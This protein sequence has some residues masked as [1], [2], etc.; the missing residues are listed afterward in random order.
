MSEVVY[1][2]ALEAD[3]DQAW[4]SLEESGCQ[5]LYS[6]QE[7]MSQQIIGYLPIHSNAA[8]VLAKHNFVKAIISAPLPAIDWDAQWAAHGQGYRDGYLHIDLHDFSPTLR[9]KTLKLKPGPGFGDL[10]HPTTRLVLKLMHQRMQQEHVI[11]VGCGS[12]I[13]ALAALSMGA[14]SV[15]AID[16][17]E[18]ALKHAEINCRLNGMQGQIAFAKP[19]ECIPHLPKQKPLSILMNMIHSEQMQAWQ[20]LRDIHGQVRWAI[21]SGILCE[22]EKEYLKCCAKWGWQPA[23]KM[24]EEGWMGFIFDCSLS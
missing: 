4:Q 17:D 20:S 22:E 10:S 16:I 3:L 18:E 8:Q 13:L 23:A 6:T 12:G 15:W 14:G 21:T 19:E 2:I 5:L 1:H 11:D 24:I 9:P 7:K